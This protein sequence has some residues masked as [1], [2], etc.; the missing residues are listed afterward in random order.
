[1]A[2]SRMGKCT[3]YILHKS[4]VL[5]AIVLWLKL[6]CARATLTCFNKGIFYLA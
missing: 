3:G 1:M 2:R 4:I 5:R 6:R